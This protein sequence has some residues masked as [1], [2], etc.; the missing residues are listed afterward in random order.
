MTLTYS[1]N[2]CKHIWTYAGGH[3]EQETRSYDCPCNNG[4]QYHNRYIPFVGNDYYC[5]SGHSVGEDGNILYPNDLLWDG[6]DCPGL[7]STCCTSSKMPWFVKTLNETVSEDIE[8]TICGWNYNYLT[9]VE[10]T[11]LDLI[12]LYVK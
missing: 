8:L 12:E 4:S 10:G 9:Y 11:P 7:E 5:E 2:P 3:Y 1:S 6:Q